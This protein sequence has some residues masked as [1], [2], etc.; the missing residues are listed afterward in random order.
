[1][2][3]T[4]S[5]AG[6]ARIRERLGDREGLVASTLPATADGV[7]LFAA[8]TSLA[9]PLILLVPDARS[10]RTEPAVPAGTLVVLTPSLAH[11]GPEAVRLGLSPLIL[12]EGRARGA[13]FTLLETPGADRR[14]CITLLEGES[15]R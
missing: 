3:S 6:G 8:L 7:A 5:R 13:A 10:W 2:S 15:P 11:L 1:M 9:S 4:R 12:G 14:A